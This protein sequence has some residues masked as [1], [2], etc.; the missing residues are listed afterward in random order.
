MVC[1]TLVWAHCFITYS[2]LIKIG[3]AI[4]YR[5]NSISCAAD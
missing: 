4:P 2:V 3:Q 5:F 1:Q